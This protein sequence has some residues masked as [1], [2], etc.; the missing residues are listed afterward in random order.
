MKNC[1]KTSPRPMFL[2]P[3]RRPGWFFGGWAGT[4]LALGC[5][6]PAAFAANGPAL[7]FAAGNVAGDMNGIFWNTTSDTGTPLAIW[8]ASDQLT[9]GN[10]GTDTAFN[11]QTVTINLDLGQN[12]NGVLINSPGS[13]ANINVIFSGTV[14]V[15]AGAAAT[16]TVN[17]GATLTLTTTANN[18]GF[19]FNKT[20]V[21]FAGNGIINFQDAFLANGNATTPN[22]MNMPGGTVQLN[23]TKTSNFGAANGSANGSLTLTAGTLQFGSATALA[24]AFQGFA[25]PAASFAINGG[26][27]DNTSGLAGTLALGQGTYKLGG[28][29]TFPGSSSLNLGTNAVILTANTIITNLAGTLTLAGISNTAFGLT[30]TGPGALVISNL[31]TY[32]GATVVEGG[33]LVL[34]GS[35]NLPSTSAITLYTNTTLDLSGL[36]GPLANPN[37]LTMTNTTLLLKVPSDSSTNVVVGALSLGGSANTITITQLPTVAG[38]P[39][40][41]HLINYSNTLSL[42]NFVLTTP[43]PS[44]AGVPYVGHLETNTA[45]LIDLVLT[46]GPVP[47]R[48]LWWAGTDTAHN[49]TEAWDVATSLNWTNAQGAPTYYNQLDYVQFDD[50]T[51]PGSPTPGLVQLTTQLTPSTLTVSNHAVTYTLSGIGPLAD[52]TPSLH[53]QLVKQGS[54]LLIMDEFTPNTFSGGTLISA[55]SVQVGNNDGSGN[56]GTGPVVNNGTLIFDG[57]ISSFPNLISGSGSL[58]QSGGGTLNLSGANTFSG[59][60]TVSNGILQAGSATALGT[61]RITINNG[62]ILDLSGQSLGAIPVFA[63]GAGVGVQGAIDNSGATVPNDLGLEFV[64]L[65]GDTTFSTSGGPT[66]GRWDLRSPGGDAGVVGASPATSTAALST[67]GQGYNLTLLGTGFLGIVS[68]WVDPQLAN[69]DIQGGTLDYEGGTTGLGNPAANLTVEDGAVLFLYN[70]SNALNKNIILQDLS[71][72]RNNSGSNNVTGPITLNG[73]NSYGQIQVDGTTTLNLNGVI[74]GQGILSKYTGT[75]TLNLNGVN[76]F[77][78][79]LQVNAGTLNLNGDH[80]AATGAST[81]TAGTLNLNNTLGG[82]VTTSSGSTLSG[83]GPALGLVDLSGTLTPGGAN[84]AGTITAGGGLTLESS[85][86]VDFD[87]AAVNTVGGGVNDLVVVNGDLTF[88][89][90]T[91]SINAL[92]GLLQLGV[93]YR[94]FNYSGTLTLNTAPAVPTTST[95]YAFTLDTSTAGQVNITANPGSGPPLWNGGS[96]TGSDWSDGANWGGITIAPGSPL[97]FAGNTRLDNTNDTP[98]DSQYGNILFVAGAGPFVLNGNNIQMGNGILINDSSNPQTINLGIDFSSSFAFDGGSSAAAPLIIGGGLNELANATSNFFNGYGVLSNNLTCPAGGGTGTNSLE[99]TNSSA[100]WTLMDNPASTPITLPWGFEILAGTFNFGSASSAPNFTS[101]PANAGINGQDNQVGDLANATATFNM[102][103]GTLTTLAR[104]N[105]GIA[106]GSTGMIN[107]T[108]GTLNI[109]SQFQGANGTGGASFVTN[110]GGTMNIGS[111]ADPTSTFYVASRGPGVL[112]VSGSGAVNC[113]TLDVSRSINSSI[114]GT[115]NLN[116]GILTVAR[117]GTATANSTS[118]STGSTAVFNFDGGTLKASTNSTTFYQGSTVAPIIPITTIVKSGGA[119]LDDGGFA[120]S[121]LEPLQHDSTLGA[122]PDGGLTKLGAAILTLAKACTYTGP[123][124]VGNGT[125]TVSG[126]LAAASTV[127]VAAGATLNVTGAIGGS[128]TNNGT[129]TGVGT[130]GGNV[131]ITSTGTNFGTGAI[132]GSVTNSGTL[133]PGGSGTV[134]SLSVLGSVTDL[135]GSTTAMSINRGAAPSNSVLLTV[136]TLTFAGALS[137]PN[138]GSALQAGDSFKLFS[139]AAYA[140]SFTSIVPAIPGPNLIWNTNNLAVNG[141]LSVMAPIPVSI[142]AI[143]VSGT[144]LTISG[145]GGSPTAT[146]RVL[147]ATDATLPFAS[148]T[149]AGSGSFDGGGN[150]TFNGAINLADAQRFYVVVS[151]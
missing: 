30:V 18:N 88:N 97:Y 27:I 12:V 14:N 87:L 115:V 105:T 92:G 90:G 94:L 91:L 26:T 142:G 43:L 150:F 130:I 63:Q 135:A 21:T 41:L 147:S 50:T 1:C 85:G 2:T 44:L 119:I 107:Q 22:I 40:T 93:P 136:G 78:G 79:G 96:V 60:V 99:M 16:W 103:N 146:Y 151:P 139:A 116:G 17:S 36:T 140:G 20:P 86:T 114:P 132:S 144:A 46:S 77:T 29:F 101:T 24:D 4:M 47:A 117:V 39:V 38:Y 11:N 53:L 51:A 134:A 19:N 61:N 133:S 127:T 73:L 54:G 149:T 34:A 106:S 25:G 128:V 126:S 122:T 52:P 15:R 3:R 5:L 58:V 75:G 49:G 9:I 95:G 72:L 84:T 67:S 81:L 145:T 104:F 65:T 35:A 98:A 76:T 28:N 6:A 69:I 148:W 66:A 62:A 138:S 74:S 100:N 70:T 129:E 102:V 121:V 55:G 143:A 59:S 113:G 42:T 56:L 71:T 109:G 80:T 123:T 124:T 111:A 13:S 64:T 120:I 33:T 23:Q 68:A 57:G 7:Y 112:T 141:T 10:N 8:T 37:T 89:G 45:N 110:S 31:S 82:A 131:A 48:S 125:L 118:S 32:T 83:V 108:G 137:V